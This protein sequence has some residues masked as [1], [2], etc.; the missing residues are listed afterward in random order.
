VVSP[1]EKAALIGAVDCRM[2]QPSKTP[3]DGRMRRVA[4][5][6]PAT[7]ATSRLSVALSISRNE[8]GWKTTSAA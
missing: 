4:V 6:R 7:L 5:S 2:A 1:L 3:A 8:P